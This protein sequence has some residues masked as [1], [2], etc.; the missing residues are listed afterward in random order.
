MRNKNYWRLS[1][2]LLSL[3]F[4]HPLLAETTLADLRLCF[5]QADETAFTTAHYRY[6]QSG[7]RATQ[8]MLARFR[9]VEPVLDKLLREANAPAW[10]KYIPLAESRLELTVVSSAGAAG[11]W[12]IIPRTARGLGLQVDQTVDERL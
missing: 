7:K 10:L 11:I 3:L 6:T 9:Q 8:R 5:A 2:C 1:F 12:Q 4:L